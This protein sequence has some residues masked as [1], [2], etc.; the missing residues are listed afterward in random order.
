M[1]EAIKLL[2]GKLDELNEGLLQVD[3]WD[4]EMH[5]SRVERVADCPACI[6]REFTYLQADSTSRT[7]SLC[8]RDAIQIVMHGDH[9]LDLTQLAE[10]LRGV[11]EVAVNPFLLRVSID[12]YELNIFADARAIIKGTTDETIARTLYSKYVGF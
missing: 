9:K 10:R 3:V 8:G 7:T 4:G 6:G 5:R 12:G 1:T 2:T 11:G